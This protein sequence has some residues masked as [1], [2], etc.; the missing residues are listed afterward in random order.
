MNPTAVFVL[1]AEVNYNKFNLKHPF[2]K[3]RKGV[4]MLKL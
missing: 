1:N 4:F 2:G 3:F